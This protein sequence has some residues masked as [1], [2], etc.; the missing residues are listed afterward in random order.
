MRRLRLTLSSKRTGRVFHLSWSSS[1]PRVV[2][3]RVSS[4][5]QPSSSCWTPDRWVGIPR[6]LLSWVWRSFCS[7][8]LVYCLTS[9]YT[10]ISLTSTLTLYHP[11]F[12]WHGGSVLWKFNGAE[13]KQSSC[14]NN[15]TPD[16]CKGPICMDCFLL[17]VHTYIRTYMYVCMYQ[18]ICYHYWSQFKTSVWG[19][20]CTYKCSGWT[21]RYTWFDC[22]CLHPYRL[23]WQVFD[24]TQGG[25]EFGLRLYAHVNKLRILVCGGDG[26]VSWLSGWVGGWVSCDHHVTMW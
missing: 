25:P 15:A 14:T 2:A 18:Y 11:T 10:A 12:M 13:G 19:H 24:L 17:H 4:Y 21:H 8:T 23:S 26:T 1:I 9:N 5:S 7:K 6:Q 22:T 20:V 3:T 16:S